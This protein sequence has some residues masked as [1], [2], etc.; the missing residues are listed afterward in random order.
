M[1]AV[2]NLQ[3]DWN[4][5]M[6]VM[7]KKVRDKDYPGAFEAL[8]ILYGIRPANTEV[9]RAIA[10]LLS[11]QNN[12]L[13]NKRPVLYCMFEKVIEEASCAKFMKNS[14]QEICRGTRTVGKVSEKIMEKIIELHQTNLILDVAVVLSKNSETIRCAYIL[15]EYYQK[16]VPS[17]CIDKKQYDE[18]M[19][20]ISTNK[21]TVA[22]IG[23]SA[24]NPKKTHAPTHIKKAPEGA[25]GIE[26]TL[27]EWIRS[28][29]KT[30]AIM[31]I[32]EEI[33]PAK[34]SVINFDK[35]IKYAVLLNDSEFVVEIYEV[36]KKWNRQEAVKYNGH[37][38]PFILTQ[39]YGEK[40]RPTHGV[41]RIWDTAFH[42]KEI[43][44]FNK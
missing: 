40:E 8:R 30:K 23:K 6:V 29:G 26:A 44:R 7:N 16:H 38:E 22:L 35:A 21:Q 41:S 17:D 24:F 34:R 10:R 13:L 3:S 20:K 43:N 42:K 11:V 28:G 19:L 37:V 2:K 25:K 39:N 5:C 4:D 32:R 33:V 18:V 36:F 15:I 12:F 1:V 14:L 27:K 31:K 9:L